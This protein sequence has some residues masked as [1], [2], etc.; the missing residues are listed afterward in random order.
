MVVLTTA[1]AALLSLPCALLMII[2]SDSLVVRRVWMRRNRAHLVALRCLE[3]D[4]QDGIP[5]PL[6]SGR[7]S[8]E[9]AAAELRRLDRQ[10]HSGPTAGSEKWLVAVLHAYDQW[11]QVACGCLGITQELSSLCGMDREIE[12]LRMESELTAAGLRL[13]SAAPRRNE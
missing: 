1:F 6:G 7:P 13:R 9:Q 3:Q 11:L 2:R 10:R 5:R 12:R 4:L 8:L